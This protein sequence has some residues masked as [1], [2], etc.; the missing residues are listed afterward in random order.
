MDY[1]TKEHF[2]KLWKPATNERFTLPLPGQEELAALE[3]RLGVK[4]PASYIELGT[5]SQNGGFLKRNGV[6]LRNASGTITGYIKINH[7]NPIGRTTADPIYDTPQ[8]FYD[9][10][11]LLVLGENWDAYYEFFVLNYLECG[12]QGEPSVALITRKSRCGEPGEPEIGDWRYINEKYYWQSPLTV[13]Q[14][15]DEFIKQLVVMPKPVPFDLGSIKE[16]LKQAAQEAFRQIVKNNGQEGII[17]FGLYVDNEGTMVAHA[18][19]TKAHWQQQIADKPLEQDYFT[20]CIS[21]WCCEALAAQHLFD[22]ICRELAQSSAQCYKKSQSN[23]FRD[24]L[25]QLCTEVLADLK[26]DGFFAR[27]YP[28]PILLNVDIINGQLSA[29]KAKKIRLIL[30]KE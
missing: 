24:S 8:P 28:Y 7:I 18:A 23:H 17:A 13:A 11:N 21:E 30:S 29:T 4:L 9:I 20:Y 3:Q 14:T 1:F 16:S 27:E 15:F 2:Q 10:P 26:R 12:S 19:N 5:F 22:P 25:I 6:P